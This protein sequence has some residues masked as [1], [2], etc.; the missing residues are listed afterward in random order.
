MDKIEGFL[1]VGRTDDTHEVVINHPDLKPDENGVGHIVFSPRQARTLANL[2]IKN[3]T[4]AEAEAKGTHPNAG[5]TSG[6]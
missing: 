4:Y 6:G 1:E 5:I 3:A 2:L